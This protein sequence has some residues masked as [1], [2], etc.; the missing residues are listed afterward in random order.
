M[1]SFADLSDETFRVRE[2]LDAHVFI[3]GKNF[4]EV[5]AGPL[6]IDLVMRKV[7]LEK[8]EG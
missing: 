4:V 1:I 8:G 6:S 5:M 3:G 7:R 2:L